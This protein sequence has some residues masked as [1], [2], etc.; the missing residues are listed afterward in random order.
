MAIKFVHDSSARMYDDSDNSQLFT[1]PPRSSEY[2]AASSVRVSNQQTI[3]T[4]HEALVVSDLAG[5]GYGR[6]INRDATNFAQVGIDVA[7]TFYPFVYLRPG[8]DS[9]WIP[10]PPSGT[11]LYAKADTA[12][13]KL[14]YDLTD[15]CT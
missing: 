11:T 2:T 15:V 13:V 4:T 12:A 8:Q 10:L 6:F 7:A 14:E 3:G 9:G 5:L 1:P